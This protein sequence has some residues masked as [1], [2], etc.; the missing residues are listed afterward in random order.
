VQRPRGAPMSRI[1]ECS[2]PGARRSTEPRCQPRL[3]FLAA[4]AKLG[5]APSTLGRRPAAIRLMHVGARL[6]SP[7]DALQVDA[8]MRGIRRAWKRPVV[9]KAPA[10]DDEIK[11]RK[12][13]VGAFTFSGGQATGQQ[14]AVE[15]S[16]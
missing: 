14:M 2:G 10:V 12:F 4:Q 9:E 8:V 13:S 15:P 7:H 16:A 3:P 11:E 1:G 5:I 6:A